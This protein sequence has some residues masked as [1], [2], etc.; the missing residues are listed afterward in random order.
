MTVT[1]C[2]RV[3]LSGHI[4]VALSPLRA[5]TL[6]TPAGERAWAEGWDPQFPCPAADDTEPGVVFV[7]RHGDHDTTWVVIAREPPAAIRYVHVTPGHRAGIISVGCQPAA[8]GTRVTV[9]YDLTALTPE[10][11]AE[12]DRFAADYPHFLAR[13]EQAIARAIA[14]GFG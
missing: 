9:G 2:T 13:W 8:T 3:R 7:T 11:N 4:D 5:F 10:A 1:A 12:L 6:F 14:R